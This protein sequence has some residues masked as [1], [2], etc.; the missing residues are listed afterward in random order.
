MRDALN[1][2]AH[3]VHGGGGG[4][5]H[6]VAL[7]HDFTS[8]SVDGAHLGGDGARH[9]CV[10]HPAY[11]V[12]G[13]GIEGSDTARQCPAFGSIAGV[14]GVENTI[15]RYKPYVLFLALVLR[16]GCGARAD[17]AARLVGPFNRTV[18]RVQRIE[19]LVV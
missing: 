11:G 6:A 7:P 2:L 10:E 19:F 17:L 12:V 16:D 3:G 5:V 13:G 4:D 15:I 8:A 1:E 9:V 14:E 18:V